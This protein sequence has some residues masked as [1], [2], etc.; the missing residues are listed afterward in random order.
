MGK[1][2]RYDRY[3]SKREN[4]VAKRRAKA[5]SKARRKARHQK[6]A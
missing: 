2:I 6:A 1:T 4:Y 3:R 5:K